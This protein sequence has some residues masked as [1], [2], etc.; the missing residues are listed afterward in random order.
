[1]R[2]GRRKPSKG[3]LSLLINNPSTT[4]KWTSWTDAYTELTWL[5]NSRC[6]RSLFPSCMWWHEVWSCWTQWSAYMTPL[7]TLCWRCSLG[8]F[9]HQN[10]S[11][12]LEVLLRATKVLNRAS[13]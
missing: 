6:N 4:C 3:R 9:T 8:V 10:M 13:A 7:V 5:Q 12:L 2:E 1:M 11:A